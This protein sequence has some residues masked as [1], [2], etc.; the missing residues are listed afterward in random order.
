MSSKKEEKDIIDELIEARKGRRL[1]QEEMAKI[2]CCPQPSISRVENRTVSPTLEFVKKMCD[3]LGV[4]LH[5][6]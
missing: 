1:T 3:V 2:M 6:K 5:L 4:G